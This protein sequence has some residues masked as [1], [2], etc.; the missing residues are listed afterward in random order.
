MDKNTL[1]AVILSVVVI[2]VGFMVQNILYPPEPIPQQAQDERDEGRQPGDPADPSGQQAPRNGG[3]TQEQPAAQ[4]ARELTAGAVAPVPEDGISAQT[5]TYGNDVIDVTFSPRGASITSFKLLEHLAD[6]EPVDM[7]FRGRDDQAAF[8]LHFGGPD[9]DADTALYHYRDTT[10]PN[11][12]EFYRDFYVVGNEAEPFRVI[13]RYNFQ[14][15]EYLFEVE[16]EIENSVNAYIPLNFDGTAY[17][18]E[19]GPQIGPE[20]QE[21]DRRTEYRRYYTYADGNRNTVR[22]GRGD[23]EAI[24]E[25][26]DWASIVGKYFNAVGILDA[27][28]YT[29]VMS[30]IPEPGLDDASKMFFSRST[31]QSSRN[32]DT[33]RFFIGPKVARV[34]ERYNNADDN[35]WGIRGL[36]LQESMD[37]RFL[38]G[39]LE[40]LLKAI[41]NF[42]VRFVPNFGIAI[43]ILTVLVKA[44]LFPL[45]HKS[46]ES[47]AKMQELSPKMQEVREKYKDN[48]QKMNAE[49]ANMY[50]KEGVNPLG[51]CLPLMLQLP[52]F[53]AMF[54]LFNNHFDL[55]G[56]TFIPGWIDDLSAP[57]SIL[58]FGDFTLPLL[59]WT[60]LRLLPILFVGTQLITSKIMQNPG[61]STQQMRMITYML[62]IVFFFVLYNMPSGLLVYWIVTNVLTAAQQYF[63][64]RKK[65][66]H[67]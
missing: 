35:A 25:Q 2:T 46:Y 44:L 37:S 64:N 34:L 11:T 10:D 53:I 7:I 8:R 3:S 62:P 16:V 58:S 18:L 22:M 43:I 66:R 31:I 42:I 26:I 28:Q 30:A 67:A 9:S 54:G 29:T 47:T 45:T 63:N 17:T 41:L 32:T 6:G 36:E 33:F 55:R 50:K 13:K 20:F 61:A 27:A 1:Y 4:P 65:H 24:T 21:L 23:R 19:F 48:P 12:V 40:N 38:L 57:E 60:D 15:G 5:R 49:M 39:W 59:G 14:P 52:F 56:A 51:G